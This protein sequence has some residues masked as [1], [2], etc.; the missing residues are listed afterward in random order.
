MIHYYYGDGKG[1]TTAAMGLAVRAL[2]RGKRVCIVQFLKDGPSGEISFLEG[3]PGV[4]ICRGKAGRGFTF[5][6]TD[7]EKAE[8]ARIHNAN[9]RQG[10]DAASNGACGVLILDEVGDALSLGLLDGQALLRF[11]D[12]PALSCEVVMTGHA[13]LSDLMERSDYV[14]QMQKHKH[15]YDRGVAARVGIE[16]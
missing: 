2:G 16:A 12:T 8:T 9:L 11:L 4:T 13:P 15:P 14:T 6:M 10:C 3:V 1:K 5:Q 7:E